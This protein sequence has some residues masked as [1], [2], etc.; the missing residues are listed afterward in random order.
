MIAKKKKRVLLAFFAALVAGLGVGAL[1]VLP[2]FLCQAQLNVQ[3]EDTL[4]QLKALQQRKALREL[5]DRKRLAEWQA[6]RARIRAQQGLPPLPPQSPLSPS[7][8]RFDGIQWELSHPKPGAS[9]PVNDRYRWPENNQRRQ[10]P[11]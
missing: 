2:D 7:L 8:P 1:V 4:R 6:L 5:E 9:E 3:H 10:R 11:P